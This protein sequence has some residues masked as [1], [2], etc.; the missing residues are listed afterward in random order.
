MLLQNATAKKPGQ[1][2][3]KVTTQLLLQHD[4]SEL[5]MYP[6]SLTVSHIP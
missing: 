4:L 2:L 1:N 3:L 5:G 6:V